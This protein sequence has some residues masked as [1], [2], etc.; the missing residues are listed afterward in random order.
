MFSHLWHLL[1]PGEIIYCP[2]STAEQQPPSIQSSACKLR[3]AKNLEPRIPGE[4][5]SYQ[6]YDVVLTFDDQCF[7][8]PDE[9]NSRYFS[10]VSPFH[11]DCMLLDFDRKHLRPMQIDFN[12]T[13]FS[14]PQPTNELIVFPFRYL[15]NAKQNVV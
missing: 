8:F 5:C 6:I 12:I 14:G 15:E 13:P 9:V 10:R 3:T 7:F 2:T 4:T 11:I 1:P